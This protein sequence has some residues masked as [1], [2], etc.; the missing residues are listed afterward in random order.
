MFWFAVFDS[1]H[2][3]KMIAAAQFLEHHIILQKSI[4]KLENECIA[5]RIQIDIHLGWSEQ[6]S[7]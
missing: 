7:L 4:S 3:S 5:F 1:R 2:N 6:F